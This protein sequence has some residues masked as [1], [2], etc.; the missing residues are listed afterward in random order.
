[1]KVSIVFIGT[2]YKA[3]TLAKGVLFSSTDFEEVSSWCSKHNYKVQ[4]IRYID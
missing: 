3:F 4:S 2:E 1:M